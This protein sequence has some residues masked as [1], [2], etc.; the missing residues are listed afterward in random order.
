MAACDA[1]GTDILVAAPFFAGHEHNAIQDA[2]NSLTLNT[3]VATPTAQ[4][5]D[6]AQKIGLILG[7]CPRL[8]RRKSL[9][10]DDLAQAVGPDI[11]ERLQDAAA[12][13]P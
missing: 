7:V 2:L 12:V 1:R 6:E 3:T 8:I 10:A 5:L 11:A 4:P 9:T 13:F